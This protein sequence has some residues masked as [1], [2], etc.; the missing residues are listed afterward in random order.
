MHK[1][2]YVVVKIASDIERALYVLQSVIGQKYSDFKL[3]VLGYKK[4]I[5]DYEKIFEVLNYGISF[6]K[7]HVDFGDFPISDIDCISYALSEAKKEKYNYICYLPENTAFY[8]NNSLQLLVRGLSCPIRVGKNI[9]YH[10]NEQKVEVTE[11]RDSSILLLKVSNIKLHKKISGQKIGKDITKKQAD[12]TKKS[13]I[14][15]T[16]LVSSYSIWSSMK[17][18]YDFAVKNARIEPTLVY[19]RSKHFNENS[20][21]VAKE[22]QAFIDAG[23]EVRTSCDY[24][25]SKEKPDIVVTG[26]PYSSRE[27][28]YNIDELAKLG[29]KC[30]YLPY[31]MIF[32][33]SWPEL[34]RLRYRIAMQYLAW[35]TCY[36]D[37]EEAEN[38]RKNYWGNTSSIYVTGSPRIDLLKRLSEN[39]YP[40]YRNEIIRLAKGRK[41]ILWNTH[42]SIQNDTIT[43]SSWNELGNTILEYI[44][45]NENVF[46][47]WRPHPYFWGALENYIGSEH[48]QSFI[49]NITRIDNL[50]IDEAD[51]YLKSFSIADIFISDASSMVK[52]FLFLDKPVITT[53]SNMNI[54]A[55]DNIKNCSY[56][57]EN[58]NQITSVLGNLINGIDTKAEIR[59]EYIKNLM[60]S[61]VAVGKKI[62]DLLIS[63]YDDEN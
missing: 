10:E 32:E 47:I 3:L 28:G 34:I 19:V 6:E 46:F 21:G 4:D 54:I 33:T 45:S 12:T 50:L 49:E 48:Y 18:V 30:V 60:G 8:D 5:S 42:H 14:K 16:F 25:I 43:F 44:K 58:A 63:K 23:Y 61:D 62:I 41:I 35:V 40:E 57:V 38:A 27:D 13:I 9:I 59:K 51:T 15:I 52:E 20:E 26:I 55:S 1:R 53:V 29:T 11:K 31:G 39:S 24:D 17:S 36:N 37:D 56:V 2:V 22:R 7:C